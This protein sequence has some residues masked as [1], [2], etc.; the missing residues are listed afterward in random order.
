MWLD[1]SDTLS[2]LSHRP[3]S[4]SASIPTKTPLTACIYAALPLD[5]IDTRVPH[6]HLPSDKFH[7]DVPAH[8]SVQDFTH[9]APSLV[10]SCRS[11]PRHCQYRSQYLHFHLP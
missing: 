5:S 11:P 1:L 4:C 7:L 2:D 3:V 10:S 8:F 9:S 6:L